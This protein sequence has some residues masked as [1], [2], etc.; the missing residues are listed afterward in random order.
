MKLTAEQLK[1]IM[2]KITQANLDAYL[3]PLNDAM[4]KFEITTRARMRMFLANLAH[5][6]IEL[7]A[8]KENLNYSAEG[9]LKIF[10]AYF[11]AETA[12]EFAKKPEK[13]ANRVY[14]NRM[15]NGDEASGDGWKYRGKGPIQITG[16]NN[17]AAAG[18]ALGY[19]FIANP[20]AL[21]LPGAGSFA[22]AWFFHTAKCNVL[23]DNDTP[24]AFLAVVKKIN[25]GTNGLEDRKKYW[26]LAKKAIPNE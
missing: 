7:L 3:G 15:G 1:K 16:K 20:D 12:K 13:I 18:K 5:E 4:A 6:S 23:A 26:E 22:A 10:P 9:L 17:H 14:A 11:N 21:L 2:P 8:N 24:E 25:G 19:D